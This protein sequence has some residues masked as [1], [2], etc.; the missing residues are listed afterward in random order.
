MTPKRHRGRVPSRIRPRWP[1]KS[2]PSRRERRRAKRRERRIARGRRLITF[3][4]LLF[5]ILLGAVLAGAYYAV[6]WYDTNSYFVRVDHNELVVYQGRIGGFLWY[7][8]VEV[9]RTGVTTADVPA[10][11]RRCPH[12]RGGGVLGGQRG[13]LRGQSGGGQELSG[14]SVLRI[15]RPHS[16]VLTTT[17]PPT[18]AAPTTPTTAK[19][20]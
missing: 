17:A 16:R 8:P 3:R 1:R 20:P 15:L 5:I 11:L 18:T 6:E 9:K 2:P 12:Q 13:G 10:H 7:N 19:A 4:T 14:E